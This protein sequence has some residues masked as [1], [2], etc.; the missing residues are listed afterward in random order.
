M[1]RIAVLPA[2]VAQRIAAG[3][4][5]ERP[6]SVVKEACENALD[7]GARRIDV[8]LAGGGVQAITV[9]DDGSGMDADDALL[10]F[11]RHATSKLR[12]FEDLQE[13]A[14]LGFRGEALPSIAAVGRVVLITRPAGQDAATRVEL[15][16]GR[17]P[18]VSACGAAPGTE[19][20]VA[21]LFAQMPARRA[22]LGSASQ[23]L[24]RCLEVVMAQALARPDVAFRVVHEGR[25]VLQ[26]PGD[27]ELLSCCVALWGPDVARGLLAV[28]GRDDGWEIQGLAGGPSVA[29]GN[30][31][32]QFLAVDGRPVRSEVVRGAVEQA[33]HH[34]LQVRRYPLFVLHLRAARGQYDAN[35]HPSKREV[36][37]YHPEQVRR[38]CHHAVRSAL[39]R[40]DLAAEPPLAA[41]AGPPALAT[42]G[43]APA[44]VRPLLPPQAEAGEERVRWPL[45]T[46]EGTAPGLPHLR[47]LGQFAD[48]YL[49]AV[50][51]DAVYLVDQ[52]AAHERVF[53][54]AFERPAPA[55]RLLEPALLQLSADEERRWRGLADGLRRLGVDAEPFGAGALL[56]RAVPAG[57]DTDPVS[58]LADVL[59]RAEAGPDTLLAARRALAACKA[60][61][62]A[63]QRLALADQEALLAQ[64]AA[65]RQPYTCPHGR[66][67][68][69]RWSRGELERHFGRR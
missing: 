10:A 17:A 26:T 14:T 60:A 33:Y 48:S 28:T 58:A 24:A 67:T 61:I 62:K 13:L 5:I 6:A 8:R 11:Q 57:L 19:L 7:A 2:E 4:V 64:L 44:A 41:A 46:E 55:R 40:A 56:I 66:P 51:P 23:E 45:P 20:S 25:E 29:R 3:E 59:A 54:E 69:L 35:V 16:G 52:H 39:A 36:R 9:R 50:G 49:I 30:R 27:G 68:I 21:D 65:C 31:Q 47:P 15:G 18:A 37:V 22:A 53:F 12:R 42:P 38:L 34:L 32:A 1:G 63:G 43:P